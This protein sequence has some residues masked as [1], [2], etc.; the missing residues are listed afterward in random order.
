MGEKTE[1][2]DLSAQGEEDQP[3]TSLE[4]SNSELS[5]YIFQ[6]VPTINLKIRDEAGCGGS[7]L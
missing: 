6:Q 7:R 2:K 4:K 1:H 5:F 3:L